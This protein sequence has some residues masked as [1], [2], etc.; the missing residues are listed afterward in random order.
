MNAKAPLV[1]VGVDGSDESVDALKWAAS[2]GKSTG[3]TVRAIKCWHYPWA[4]Q[5]APAQIDHSV[6]QQIQGE[7]EAAVQKASGGA[8]IERA[9]REGHA[10]QVLVTESHEIGRAHV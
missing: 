8:E 4:M 6:E 5:T 9:V 3:A 1:I 2:Y 10:S 7:L